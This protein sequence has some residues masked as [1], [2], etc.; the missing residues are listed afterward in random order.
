MSDD[1]E[2]CDDHDQWR[3][4]CEYCRGLSGGTRNAHLTPGCTFSVDADEIAW[5]GT[6]ERYSCA[7][8]AI[9]TVVPEPKP[10]SQTH[11]CGSCGRQMAV[12]NVTVGWLSLEAKKELDQDWALVRSDED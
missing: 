2:P 12:E 3:P 9:E 8:C 4:Y 1:N 7:D 10:V 6:G 5:T 11:L